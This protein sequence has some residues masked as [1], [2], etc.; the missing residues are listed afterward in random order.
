M[1]PDNDVLQEIEQL[2]H[3]YAEN[4]DGLVFARLA[5]A[6]RRTGDFAKAEGLILHGLKTHPTYIS[7]HNVLGRVYLDAERLADAH[8]QFN[9]VLELDPQN[10]IALRALGDLAMNGGRLEDARSW[11]EKILFIDPRNQD[12]LDGLE[13]L[14]SGGAPAEATDAAASAIQPATAPL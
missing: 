7:G 9:K 10:M 11:Y 4:P 3:R 6:Y 1:P 5:D 12:A 14:D 2:E 8:E 13:M